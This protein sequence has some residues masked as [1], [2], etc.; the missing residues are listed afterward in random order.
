[1]AAGG[2]GKRNRKV[3]ERRQEERKGECTERESGK[4]VSADSSERL[5]KGEGKG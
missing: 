4:C 3:R 1:M 2:D 5:S